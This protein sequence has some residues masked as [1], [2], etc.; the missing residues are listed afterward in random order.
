MRSRNVARRAP[1]A[2]SGSHGPFGVTVGRLV[3]QRR[4]CREAAV[5]TRADAVV[6]R[7]G[8]RTGTRRI[9][10]G[11][12]TPETRSCP[13][14][15]C[16]AVH[17]QRVA[18]DADGIRDVRRSTER[19][20]RQKA[21]PRTE[22]DGPGAQ[23]VVR[24]RKMDRAVDRHAIEDRR[25]AGQHNR[26]ATGHIDVITG[27]WHLIRPPHHRVLGMFRFADSRSLQELVGRQ[28]RRRNAHVI[29]IAFERQSS[30]S[31]DRRE[32]SRVSAPQVT[33]DKLRVVGEDDRV[34]DRARPRRLKDSVYVHLHFRQDALIIRS[35][36][37]DYGNV[38]PLV[39][40]ENIIVRP[41][42]F[43]PV[44]VLEPGRPQ[45]ARGIVGI[46][47]PHPEK[48]GPWIVPS[49]IIEEV[50]RRNLMRGQPHE[51]LDRQLRT[52]LEV[53]RAP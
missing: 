43:P 8:C 15:K 4:C 47:S 22:A 9:M 12:T 3:A 32:S 23:T 38:M 10:R 21:S 5:R 53:H 34:M 16:T 41:D 14:N 52:R 1:P 7:V 13:G 2:G 29:H 20:A 25:F 19:L 26:R 35:R 31:R 11:R 36:V 50:I 28:R 46:P 51:H 18:N 49:V 27:G 40:G 24:I 37:N 48:A 45:L 6:L 17:G 33:K 39:V 42:N 44:L 30:I